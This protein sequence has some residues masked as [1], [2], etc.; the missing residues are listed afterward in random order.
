MFAALPLV[1]KIMA[2]LGVVLAIVGGYLAWQ[3]HQQTIGRE[4]ERAE[5][6]E[7][8]FKQQQESLGY[9]IVGEAKKLQATQHAMQ[10]K[11]RFY[12]QL[13]REV[14]TDDTRR[15]TISIPEI[16]EIPACTISPGVVRDV[17]RWARVLNRTATE[18]DGTAGGADPPVSGSGAADGSRGAR[19]GEGARRTDP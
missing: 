1:W 5:H 15:P 6:L 14:V 18:R 16:Q 7:D 8:L 12:A 19:D 10:Q 11:D 4:L 3:Y 2:P 9:Y 13:S 17:N